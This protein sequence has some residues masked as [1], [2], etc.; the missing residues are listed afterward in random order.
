MLNLAIQF[1][2]SDRLN[3]AEILLNKIL[4]IY[5]KNTDAFCFQSVVAAHKS[6]FRKALT[7]IDKAIQ[8]APNNSVA[9]LNKGNILKDLGRYSEAINCYDKALAIEPNFVD[10]ISNKG[11]VLQ[12]LGRYSEAIICYDEAILIE[13]NFSEAYKNQGNALQRLGKYREAIISYRSAIALKNDFTLAWTNMGLAHHNLKNYDQSIYF[14][15]KA[16]E[17]D[18]NCVQAWV[19]KGSS[20]HEKYQYMNAI[21][22]FNNAIEINSNFVE[23]WVEK[24][25]STYKLGLYDEA[26]VCYQRA[27]SLNK[28]VDL[29]LGKIIYT[30]QNMAYWDGIE[31]DT[32]KAIAGILSGEKCI[33]PLI[34]I[35]LIDSPQLAL[36]AAE[37]IISQKEALKTHTYPI[38]KNT[39]QKIHIGYFSG[40]FKS[41]PVSF[42]IAELIEIH[43][44]SRFKIFAFSLDKSPS[45]DL[46]RTRLV[47]IFDQFIDAEDM[48]HSEIASISKNLE[49]DIAVDLG[50]H[51]EGGAIDLFSQRLAPIQV[52]YLGYAGTSGARYMDY[53]IADKTVIPTSS[54]QYYSEKIAYLPDT[55][56]VDDTNRIPSSKVFSKLEFGLPEHGIIF[57]CFNNGSKFNRS[58]LVSWAKILLKVEG[59]IFWISEN[60]HFFKENLLKEFIDLGINSERVIFAK[61]MDSMGD[62]LAR[63][64]VADLFLDTYP[65]N[66]HTTAID[67]LKSGLPLITCTGESFAGR[68]ATSLL[69]SIKMPELIA[70]NLE[71]YEA[72]AI[73]LAQNPEKLEQIKFKLANNRL[74]APLFNTPRFTKNIEAAYIKMHERK[75][76]DLQPDHI[77]IF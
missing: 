26:L 25:N 12:D 22:C 53:I 61:K 17:L 45:E 65:Y 16:L 54:Q 32:D 40:D 24:G 6:E 48:T 10:A 73:E 8:V 49:I 44:R 7:W 20:L 43:D 59:S 55:F 60:N 9:Y 31:N 13:P 72:L 15:E 39:H 41:H 63:Y 67:A 58:I 52:N 29:L 42:L 51:T 76:A 23:A 57:C 18:F 35:S 3:D 56:M 62:Y 33:A 38:K 14:H 37:N 2:Q 69:H 50:G 19:N 4:K 5:P 71:E 74:T 70:T 66:A 77:S 1:I 36:K 47:D 68:V 27:F 75:Q 30:K 34:A 46:M 28:E 11:N 21:E 64:V